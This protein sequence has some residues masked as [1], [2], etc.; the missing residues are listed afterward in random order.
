M[1]IT[2]HLIEATLDRESVKPGES[3]CVDLSPPDIGVGRRDRPS[4]A[5]AFCLDRSLSME[6]EAFSNGPAKW[7]IARTTLKKSFELLDPNIAIDI[8][9]FSGSTQSIFSGTVE[10]FRRHR[11]SRDALDHLRLLGDGTNLESAIVTAGH[12]LSQRSATS[13]RCILYT[14]GQPNVGETRPDRL[15]ECVARFSR[16]GVHFDSFGFGEDADNAL[17][18]RIVGTTGITEHVSGLPE[19]VSAAND[20]IRDLLEFATSATSSTGVIELTVRPDFEVVAVAQTIPRQQLLPVPKRGSKGTT[21]SLTLG[22]MQPGERRPEFLVEIR[23]PESAQNTV[24]VSFMRARGYIEIG[25]RRIDLNGDEVAERQIAIIRNAFYYNDVFLHTLKGIQLQNEVDRQI[26]E[27]AGNAETCKRIYAQAM[28][29]ARS[30][31][32]HALA[33]TYEDATTKL[34]KGQLSAKDAKSRQQV[35]SSKLTKTR[36]TNSAQSPKEDLGP[37][38]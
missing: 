27:A 3:F 4:C 6:D 20:K 28:T 18:S 38:L 11:P 36:V 19:D 29:Q 31:G 32:H 37:P 34:E 25:G 12:A 10:Q 21:F 26:G 7:D 5:I 30:M 15:A 8:L 13:R 17:L 23:T 16:Q 14:D 35:D 24:P 1:S 9:T 33:G 2:R 22:A